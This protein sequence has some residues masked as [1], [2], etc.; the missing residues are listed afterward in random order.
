MTLPH[1][2]FY[3]VGASDHIKGDTRTSSIVILENLQTKMWDFLS[4]SLTSGHISLLCAASE[5][6]RD[7]RR[8]T[9]LYSCHLCEFSPI[10]APSA[11]LM[12]AMLVQ[13]PLFVLLGAKRLSDINGGS[14]NWQS[15][16]GK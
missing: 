1:L 9:H 11:G 12:Y 3:C 15:H 13:L 14:G 16:F 7:K 5:S 4:Q 6:D 10:E 8:P 2:I